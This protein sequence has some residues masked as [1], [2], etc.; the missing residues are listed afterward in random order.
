MVVGLRGSSGV[1]AHL[2]V[3]AIGDVKWRDV[4]SLAMRGVDV[5]DGGGS[6]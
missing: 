4:V 6:R 3:D 5:V 1:R 2:F